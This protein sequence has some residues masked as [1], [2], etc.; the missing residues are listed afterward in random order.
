[1]SSTTRSKLSN[2][3]AGGFVVAAELDK[4]SGDLVAGAG[5]Y[6]HHQGVAGGLEGFQ[7][8]IGGNPLEGMGGP[9]HAGQVVGRDGGG[10]FGKGLIFG[11]T[12]EEAEQ[13]GFAAPKTGQSAAQIKAERGGKLGKGHGNYLLNDG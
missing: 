1:M 5:A 3:P 13:Q 9:L 8:Q 2:V 7:P 11:Q 10:Q 6:R 4:E 12:A